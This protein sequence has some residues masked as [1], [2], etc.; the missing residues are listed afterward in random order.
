VKRKAR[1]RIAER[2]ERAEAASEGAAS[3]I[4]ATVEGF[5]ADSRVGA[6]L[7]LEDGSVL[8]ERCEAPSGSWSAR[9]VPVYGPLTA[10]SELPGVWW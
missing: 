1:R 3:L 8:C 5:E 4:H 9:S 7:V 2:L 6:R 10:G